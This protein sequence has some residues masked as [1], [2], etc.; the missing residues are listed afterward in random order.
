[1]FVLDATGAIAYF[2]TAAEPLLGASYDEVGPLPADAWWALWSP[3]N[4][5]GTPIPLDRL[6]IMVALR[7]RRPTHGW[8][9]FVG[10][11]GVHRRIEATAFPLVSEDGLL[12]GAMGLFWEPPDD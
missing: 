8:L 5:E 6:P 1:M 9:D 2:N 7:E 10:L 3:T 11:D 4:I 12:L